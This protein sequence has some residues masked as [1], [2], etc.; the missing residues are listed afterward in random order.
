MKWVRCPS[1]RTVNDLDRYAICDGCNRD[2]AG[3]E[4]QA[5]PAPP[6]PARQGDLDSRNGG[7][8]LWVLAGGLLLGTVFL[9]PGVTVL[10]GA[11]SLLLLAI[12]FTTLGVR[13][14]RR[15]PY[16]ALGRILGTLLALVAGV[17]GAFLLVIV[18]C[19]VNLKN[20]KM[21]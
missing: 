7:R 6:G 19:S 21:G 17:G 3:V 13:T 8:L 9:P 1:C 2:L 14:V 18:A 16:G 20:F 11:L 12:L 10:T 4:P 15:S 5:R